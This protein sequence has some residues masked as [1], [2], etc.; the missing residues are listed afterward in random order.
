[1]KAVWNDTVVAESDATIVVESNHYFPPSSVKR[2]HLRKSDKQTV[3][4]WKGTASYF[5]VVVGDDV[6]RDAAW[7]YP[8]TKEKAKSIEGYIAFWNGVQIVE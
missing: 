4:G 6:N 7:V 1:M 8:Q 5:D 3:C 2:E